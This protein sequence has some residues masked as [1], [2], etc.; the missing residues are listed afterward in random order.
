MT[1]GEIL[2]LT[3]LGPSLPVEV[4]MVVPAVSKIDNRQSPIDNGLNERPG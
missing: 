4:L 3:I 2:R 1:G